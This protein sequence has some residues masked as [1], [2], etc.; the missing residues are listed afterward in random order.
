MYTD[1]H[2][3]R[4]DTDSQ[5]RWFAF[6]LWLLGLLW[7]FGNVLGCKGVPQSAPPMS[8]PF[9][10][11]TSE[12][13]TH[14]AM[15]NQELDSKALRCMEL[16][17]CEEVHFARALVSLFEN[18]EAAQASFR[19]VIADNAASPLATSSQLWLRFI[20]DEETGGTA[21]PATPSTALVAQFVRDWME[22]QVAESRKDEK[23]TTLASIQEALTA[24][25]RHLQAIQKQ[26][27]ERDRN[28]ANLRSQLD[29]LKLIDE[30]HQDKQRR[31]KPPASLIPT[32]EQFR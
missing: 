25:S 17:D 22:R 13:T 23:A 7:L 18:R 21:V 6:W 3:N 9:F 30:D 10:I 15:L 14:A 24:Q 32:S 29:A 1:T 19:R 11:P 26:V 27:R 2:I 16:A 20:T 28:I 31:V 5:R 4:R 8:V 12:D